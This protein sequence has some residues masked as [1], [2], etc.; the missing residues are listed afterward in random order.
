[1]TYPPLLQGENEAQYR[2]SFEKTYCRGP[3]TT[4]DGIEVRFRKQ[5]FD[6]CFFES[7]SAKDD[8]FS[9]KRAERLWWIRAALQDA[10]AELY[11]GW[12]NKRKCLVQNRRVAIVVLNYVVIIRFTGTK[13]AAFVTAFVAGKVTLMKIRRGPRAHKKTADSPG[14]LSDK[15]F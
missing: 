4:F 2:S 10:G 6:H 11:V 13:R 3:I 12:D 1:M 5:D 8:T 7:E 9:A 14:G 15:P